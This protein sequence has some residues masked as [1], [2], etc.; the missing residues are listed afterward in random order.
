[1]F[2]ALAILDAHQNTAPAAGAGCRI[3]T[4]RVGALRER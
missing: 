2:A 1:M 3:E 4:R